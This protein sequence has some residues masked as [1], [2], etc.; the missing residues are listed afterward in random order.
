MVKICDKIISVSSEPLAYCNNCN[1][2]AY[3]NLCYLHPKLLSLRITG[4]I[5]ACRLRSRFRT[6]LLTSMLANLSIFAC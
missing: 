1:D 6:S 2:I 5:A 4:T 3:T